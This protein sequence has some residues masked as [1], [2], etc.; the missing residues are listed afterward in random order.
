MRNTHALMKKK[1]VILSLPGCT[2]YGHI[3]LP[4]PAGVAYTRCYTTW[5][6]RWHSIL[7]HASMGQALHSTGLIYCMLYVGTSYHKGFDSHPMVYNR[8]LAYANDAK[9]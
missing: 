1:T 8:P 5:G 6:Y 3:S 9:L 7:C 4:R 2:F